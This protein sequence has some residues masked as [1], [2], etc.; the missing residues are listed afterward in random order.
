[1]ALYPV[2][3]TGPSRLYTLDSDEESSSA[4]RDNAFVPGIEDEDDAQSSRSSDM[5]YNSSLDLAIAE[6][7]RHDDEALGIINAFDDVSA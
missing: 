2:L 1:M 6:H 7:I 5:Y 4:S 3:S